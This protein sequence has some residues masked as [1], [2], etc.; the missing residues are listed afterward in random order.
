M[1]FAAIVIG[2]LKDN[3]EPCC[4]FYCCQ[5]YITLIFMQCTG[6]QIWPPLSNHADILTPYIALDKRGYPHN[7]FLIFP[8]KHMLWVQ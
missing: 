6:A 1:T 5:V 4:I 8:Q 7:I 3:S 2:A